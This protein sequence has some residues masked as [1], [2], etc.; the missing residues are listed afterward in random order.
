MSCG[1]AMDCFA[2]LAMTKLHSE[3]DKP[4][5]RANQQKSVHPFAQ[6]YFARAVGQI[7]DLTPR[8]S[9]NEGRLAIVT[10]VRW[11]AVDA[12]CAGRT[13]M[14]RT[15]KSCGPDAAVLASS[16]LGSKAS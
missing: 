13:H 16:S 2:T 15:A 1:C 7:S 10:N 14:M 4:T 12:K 3:C 6:K 8:V 9:P 5:R 11:D